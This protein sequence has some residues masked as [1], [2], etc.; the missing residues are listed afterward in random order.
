MMSCKSTH[1]YHKAKYV[2]VLCNP[3]DVCQISV[4]QAIT[5]PPNSKFIFI[6]EKLLELI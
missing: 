1:K 4:N 5:V 3:K 6:G 2:C